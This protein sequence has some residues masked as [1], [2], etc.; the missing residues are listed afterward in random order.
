MTQQD[1]QVS[2][3]GGLAGAYTPMPPDRAQALLRDHYGMDG[4]LKRFDTEKD[5][6]FRVT[7]P[8]GKRFVLKIANPTEPFDEV[9]FQNGILRHVAV[10]DAALPV[11]RLVP[12]TSGN[13]M[14]AITDVDGSKRFVRVLSFIDGTPLCETDSNPEERVQIGRMLGRLRLATEGF[15]HPGENRQ[16]GWDVQHL[17]TLEHL[18]DDVDDPDQRTALA[19]GL[20]RFRRIEPAL[21]RQRQQVLHNDFSK[22]NIIVNHDDPDFVKGIIDFGDSVKTAIAVDVSTACLNQL[23][24]TPHDDLFWRARDIVEGYLQITELT[25]EELTLIPHLTMGRIVTRA[26]L[27]LWRTKLFPENE[28]YIM[29]NTY[30]GWH[31]LDWFLARSPDQVSDILMQFADQKGHSQ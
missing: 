4:A 25:G 20:E 26:L 16:Y 22:S 2:E 27:T 31:Q 9:D 13:D 7:T 6:T 24:E 1:T 28:T 15:S 17:L 11:P 23:P 21:R 14:F 10:R 29:R 19:A 8:D 3:Q 12:D 5:D 18:L 30:Q